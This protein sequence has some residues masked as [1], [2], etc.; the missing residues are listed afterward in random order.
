MRVSSFGGR[1]QFRPERAPD[2]AGERCLDCTIE[3]DCPFSAKRADP[4]ISICLILWILAV[5]AV[6]D[7][8]TAEGLVAAL[9]TGPYGRCADHSDNDVLDHQGG[10]E[11]RVRVW[12]RGQLP[13]VRLHAHGVGARP[14][15][16]APRVT[17]KWPVT[18]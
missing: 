14:A 12:R 18:N 1:Y 6:T 2:G 16:V 4:P 11:H 5:S 9:E 17:W 10:C 7:V 13:D 3:P 8:R 15:S